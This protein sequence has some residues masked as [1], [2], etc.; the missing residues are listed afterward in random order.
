MRDHTLLQAIARVNRPYEDEEGL[1]K[2]A[3]SFSTSWASLKTLRRL[4]HSIRGCEDIE[5]VVREIG[6]L[7]GRFSELMERGGRSTNTA[8]G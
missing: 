4:W 2:H 6:Q 5:K 1:V 7:K 8:E 3:A